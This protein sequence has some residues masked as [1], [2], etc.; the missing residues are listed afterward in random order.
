VPRDRKRRASPPHGRVRSSG[1]RAGSDRRDALRRWPRFAGEQRLARWRSGEVGGRLPLPLLLPHPA[2]LT[3]ARS[4]PSA[5][6]APPCPMHLPR[7]PLHVHAL[8]W[9]LRSTVQ[10][11]GTGTRTTLKHLGRHL[12]LYSR[13]PVNPV[14]TGL[15]LE[16]RSGRMKYP[17][18]HYLVCSCCLCLPLRYSR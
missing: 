5:S 13:V 6:P 8:N 1:R 14:T 2:P 18:N 3:P 17:R 12:I 7:P 11:F 15:V 16:F 10:Y 4:G 9:V